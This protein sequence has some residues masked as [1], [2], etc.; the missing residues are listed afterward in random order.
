MQMD[1]IYQA[2]C[3]IQVVV[4]YMYDDFVSY[5]DLDLIE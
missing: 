5:L 2:W 4:L 3:R 1:Q